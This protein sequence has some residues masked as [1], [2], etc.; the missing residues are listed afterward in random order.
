M[1]FSEIRHDQEPP[2]GRAE[3]VTSIWAVAREK[4]E[5][6]QVLGVHGLGSEVGKILGVDWSGDDV[7]TLRNQGKTGHHATVSGEEGK[8][9]D[10]SLLKPRFSASK[11]DLRPG[12]RKDKVTIPPHLITTHSVSAG[13]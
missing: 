8:S 11:A 5:G 10:E 13:N 9:R 7:G 2:P 3:T 1:L 12:S 4:G 6:W